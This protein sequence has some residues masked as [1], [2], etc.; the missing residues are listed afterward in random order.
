MTNKHTIAGILSIIS[1]AFGIIGGIGMAAFMVFL[2]RTI[3]ELPAG[4]SSAPMPANVIGIIE[5]VYSAFGVAFALVGVLALIGGIFA[6][7]KKRWG[8]ALTGAVA[9]SITFYPA[10]IVAV[11]LTCLGRQEFQIPVP[12]TPMPAT[13]VA[14]TNI[15]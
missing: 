4:R 2:F 3:G 14:G 13:P 8:F 11:I 6:L 9:A 7:K 15:A 5:I 1:G 10:G 12:T